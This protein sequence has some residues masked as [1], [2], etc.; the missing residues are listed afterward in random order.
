M[1]AP[2]PTLDHLADAALLRHA[3]RLVRHGGPAAGIDTVTLDEFER[4]AGGE[5]PRIAAEVRSGRYRFQPVRRAF[6]PKDGGGMRRLGIPA[7]C[8]RIVQQSLRLVLHPVIDPTMHA[9]SFAYRAGRDAPRAIERLIEFRNTVGPWVVE[10]D[11]AEFFDSVP[12]RPLLRLVAQRCRDP[13]VVDLVQR[14]LEAGVVAGRRFWQA[15]RGICQ[16]SPL[17]PLLANLYLNTFD[18]ALARSGHKLIRYADDLVLVCSSRA[19]A[20]K[21]LAQVKA[22]LAKLNLRINDGKTRIVDARRESFEFLGFL[23]CPDCL[24]PAPKNVERFRRTID[25]WTRNRNGVG[26]K[27]L[28]QRINALVA[29]FAAYYRNCRAPKDFAALNAH[30]ARRWLACGLRG[31]PRRLS[32]I[33]DCPPLAGGNGYGGIRWPRG[34][35]G[36]AK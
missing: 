12:H 26:A 20:A 17:S 4:R 19:A 2:Q 6:V 36:R 16:G 29:T 7:V 8:D 5:L 3:W 23:I 34:G 28:A 22:E 11:V 21:A 1:T 32:V 18:H 35:D 9:S 30:V 27:E 15:R 13:R 31:R 25:G 10:S 24:R 33:R 14:F